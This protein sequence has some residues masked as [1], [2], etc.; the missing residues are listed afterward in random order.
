MTKSDE[1]R[2][3]FGSWLRRER[4]RR[5]WSDVDASLELG[6]LAGRHVEPSMWRGW[7]A[8]N[9]HPSPSYTRY[10]SALF[11]TPAPVDYGETAVETEVRGLGERL[12][13]IVEHLA[14][15]AALVAEVRAL[16]EELH[17]HIES[18]ETFD[19]S[20]AA[21]RDE[22]RGAVTRL[23]ALLRVTPEERQREVD[24]IVERIA[25]AE[26]ASLLPPQ[27]PPR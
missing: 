8:G 25:Q 1:E 10:L 26:R 7:E 14:D 2:G 23:D 18:S 12:D 20:I 19:A 3:K 22:V 4:L 13:V 21:L 17:A 5:G 24:E 6:E 15:N 16:R 27:T 9:T 11:G